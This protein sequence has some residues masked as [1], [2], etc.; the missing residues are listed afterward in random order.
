ML[1][2]IGWQFITHDNYTHFTTT[3]FQV[4]YNRIKEYSIMK[5]RELTKKLVFI[6]IA[7]CLVSGYTFADQ[8]TLPIRI[9]IDGVN[10]TVDDSGIPPNVDGVIA[11][12]VDNVYI[13][14]DLLAG[15]YFNGDNAIIEYSNGEAIE[16]RMIETIILQA[17]PQPDGSTNY[18]DGKYV[19][20]S[21]D[22]HL[23]IFSRGVVFVTCYTK[24][25]QSGWG[26][27]FIIMEKLRGIKWQVSPA[28]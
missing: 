27:K 4:A 22:I 21:D 24:D 1:P 14:H 28:P 9:E 17:L 10:F 7:M 15:R 19:Y 11:K 25:G 13:A 20:T 5:M 18:T 16:Y 6:L 8:S 26:R 2:L 23:R 12:F 3:Q